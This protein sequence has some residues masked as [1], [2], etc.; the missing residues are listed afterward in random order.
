MEPSCTAGKHLPSRDDARTH[1]GD[2]PLGGQA[3]CSVNRSPK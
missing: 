2:S 1:D 3:V